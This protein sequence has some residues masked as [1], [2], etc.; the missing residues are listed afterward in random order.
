MLFPCR[1]NMDGTPK[2][3]FGR[4]GE[5]NLRPV[6]LHCLMARM[7]NISGDGMQCMLALKFS[8]GTIEWNGVRYLDVDSVF[9][10]ADRICGEGLPQPLL[11][12]EKCGNDL[13]RRSGKSGAV[14]RRSGDLGTRM[15]AGSRKQPAKKA[16]G[17][18]EQGEVHDGY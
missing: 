5:G 14:W 16:A 13:K 2:D 15:K 3:R 4:F 12:V 9:A 8:D 18:V 6:L 11:I 17:K 1:G 10:A 7:E